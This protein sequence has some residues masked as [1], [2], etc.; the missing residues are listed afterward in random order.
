MSLYLLPIKKISQIKRNKI[1]LSKGKKV[2]SDKII[3]ISGYLTYKETPFCACKKASFT[4]EA[5]VILPLFAGF[6][7]AILFFFRVMQVQQSV[8]E[9]LQYTARKMAIYAY[10]CRENAGL[11]DYAAAEAVFASELKNAGCPVGY[12]GQGGIYLDYLQSS[13]QGNYIELYAD[14][15]VVLPIGLFGRQEIPITQRIKTRKWTGYQGESE[16]EETDRFVYVTPTGTVYHN[17]MDCAYLDLSIQSVSV[18]ELSYLRNAGGSKYKPCEIC[19]KAEG[20][21]YIT[22]YGTRYHSSLTCSGLKRIV[23]LIRLSEAGGY[24]ACSKCVK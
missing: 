7:A 16:Y 10:E 21:V 22:D 1:S 15:E 3:S 24:G 9:A 23:Y 6:L 19:G 13:F 14:Y 12:V 5:A 4:V 20:T 17:S 18:A 2:F 8:E 11:V